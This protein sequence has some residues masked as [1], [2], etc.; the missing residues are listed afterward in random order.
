MIAVEWRPVVGEEGLYEVSSAGD[1]RS[2]DR[3]IEIV[4]RW[5]VARRR[6]AGRLLRSWPDCNGY[7]AVYLSR[8]R[9]VNV[10]RLVALAF[11][12]TPPPGCTDVNHRDGDKANNAVDN[13]EWCT[14]RENMVHARSLGLAPSGRAVIATPKGGGDPIR[15][16][17]RA[18]A[19][20]ALG[21][22]KKSGNIGSA[23]HGLIPS[24]Y[25]YTWRYADAEIQAAA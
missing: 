18:A 2:L 1:V 4:G 8:R 13:L 21:D 7:R 5:G 25:G 14:R 17:N 20:L 24:A 9:A 3:A 22:P 11:L 16:E 6:L 23:L 10:H 12:G 19:A 15:F